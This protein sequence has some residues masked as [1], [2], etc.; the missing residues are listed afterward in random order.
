[1]T[2]TAFQYGFKYSF[3]HFANSTRLLVPSPFLI[4]SQSNTVLKWEKKVWGFLGTC[5]PRYLYILKLLHLT[6]TM[7][8]GGFLAL[9][10]ASIKNSRAGSA[11]ALMRSRTQ[12]MAPSKSSA[13][14]HY[15]SQLIH[16]YHEHLCTVHVALRRHSIKGTLMWI[17]ETED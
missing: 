16:S 8:L 12:W 17:C 14:P 1:M 10:T 3:V 5:L 6:C 7:L 9:S 2:V 13:V 15:L 11:R 4:S